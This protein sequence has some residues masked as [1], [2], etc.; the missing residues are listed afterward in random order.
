ME[1][2]Q[3]RDKFS[4][5][6]PTLQAVR[7]RYAVLVP[8]VETKDGLSLLYEVRSGSLRHHTGEVCFPGGKMEPGET[9]IQCALRETCEELAIP[10]ESV[11]I[12][13]E[14]DFLYL[15]SDGL[16]YPI[17]AKV[18]ASAL[19][20][21]RCNPGEVETW[22][23]VPLSWLESHPPK[24][25][26]Y[27][28]QPQIGPDFPYEAVGADPSYP[29]SAGRMEVPVYEGLPHPLWGLTGRITYWLLHEMNA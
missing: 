14:L 27:R 28:L 5:H 2:S 12:L 1:V 10:P 11:E 24:L 21:I 19:S 29:W 16:M 15:R 18:D 26:H 13:G 6:V 9:P 8:L 3:F 7:G 20:A 25:Y 23:T 4:G 22:F 17:L